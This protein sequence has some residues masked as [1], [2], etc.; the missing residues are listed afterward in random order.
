MGGNDER[1]EIMKNIV[2]LTTS[3]FKQEVLQ[4]AGPVVVDFYAPWCGPCK[5]LAPLL[6]QLASE[7]AGRVKF[8]KSNVDEIPDVAGFY[9][10]TGV[11][12][13][14]L[15]HN[16]KNIGQMVGLSSGRQLKAWL[17]N[18]A[19]QPVAAEAVN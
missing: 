17:E 18:A 9:G 15:F 4:A 10:I 12:T 13:L 8:A 1:I 5:M 19:A 7:L 11:P 14:M 3:N 16:G 2:E 6:E